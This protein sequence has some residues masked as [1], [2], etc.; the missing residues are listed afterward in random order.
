MKPWLLFIALLPGLAVGAKYP[1]TDEDLKTYSRTGCLLVE[2]VFSED[3]ISP[4]KELAL[5]MLQYG[6]Q[7]REE[8]HNTERAEI[9]L[10][11]NGSQFVYDTNTLVIKRI[12]WACGMHPEFRTLGADKKLKN[13]V[14]R[15]LQTHHAHHLINQLHPK[16]PND[17]VEFK[18]H[19]DIE[20]R[21]NFDKG[22]A[23]EN[24]HNG[25][26]V[27]TLTALE[28]MDEW[29]G[30]IEVYPGSHNDSTPLKNRPETQDII[31]GELQQQYPPEFV[32]MQPGD[33]LLCHPNLAH[34]SLPNQSNN[35][36]LLFINGFAAQGAHQPEVKYPGDDS[37]YLLKISE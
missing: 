6:Y 29:N 2:G 12:V 31:A 25:G 24:M 19:R 1:L 8:S 11:R 18:F 32:R 37:G 3:E 9:R 20:N 21:R 28:A 13:M 4:I 5:Q 15:V 16:M 30:A 14:F 23:G 35:S 36:R 22:W 33:V 26:F 27:Q 7:I 10:D 34:R 17:G